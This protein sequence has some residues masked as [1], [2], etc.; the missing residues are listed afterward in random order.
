MITFTYFRVKTL[1]MFFIKSQKIV[2][3]EKSSTRP[4]PSKIVSFLKNPEGLSQQTYLRR[5]KKAR[6]NAFVAVASCDDVRRAFKGRP[7]LTY[8]SWVQSF[9]LLKADHC[10]EWHID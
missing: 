3:C 8:I 5:R 1:K 6:S 4:C 9:T 7:F 2:L 10:H